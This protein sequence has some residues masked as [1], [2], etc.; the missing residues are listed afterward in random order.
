MSADALESISSSGRVSDPPI[1]SDVGPE[2]E[3]EPEPT[4]TTVMTNVGPGEKGRTRRL[5]WKLDAEEL[6]LIRRE[7]ERVMKP[8]VLATLLAAGAKVDCEE[9][10]PTVLLFVPKLGLGVVALCDGDI[11]CAWLKMLK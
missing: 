3:P 1:P 10:L 9:Q 5:D 7:E 2:P 6:S 4:V 8:D 11:G